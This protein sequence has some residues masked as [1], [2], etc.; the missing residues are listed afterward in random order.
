MFVLCTTKKDAWRSALET[1][2]SLLAIGTLWSTLYVV[3][4]MAVEV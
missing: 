2:I 1:A 3:I 4:C